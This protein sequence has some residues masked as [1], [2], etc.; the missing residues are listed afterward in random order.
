MKRIK[1]VPKQVERVIEKV[2]EMS[3]EIVEGDGG[4][5]L[6]MGKRVNFHCINYNYQGLL[7]GINSSEVELTDCKVVFETGDYNAKEVKLAEKLPK[8]FYLRLSMVE[9]YWEA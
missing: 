4:L 2:T 9:G 1:Q 6:L 3:S 7:T 5:A 8:P